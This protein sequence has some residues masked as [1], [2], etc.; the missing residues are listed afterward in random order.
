MWG[1]RIVSGTERTAREIS[2]LKSKAGT[3]KAV[4]REG[5]VRFWC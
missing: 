4:W 5:I 2:R 3:T 1:A